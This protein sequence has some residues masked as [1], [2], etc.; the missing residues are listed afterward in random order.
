MWLRRGLLHTL[1]YVH[2]N[3][4][5]N[6][7]HI[8]IDS[9]GAIGLRALKALLVVD[10]GSLHIHLLNCVPKYTDIYN[11]IVLLVLKGVVM[12]EGGFTPYPHR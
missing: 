6:C 4:F 7:V 9:Y 2:F 8:Y 5:L 10:R 12:V 3:L 11:S 1:P